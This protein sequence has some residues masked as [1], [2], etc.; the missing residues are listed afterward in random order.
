MVQEKVS[1]VSVLGLL[2]FCMF[3]NYIFF[4]FTENPDFNFAGDDTISVA[5]IVKHPI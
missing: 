1:V 3:I 5:V 2:L 4:F